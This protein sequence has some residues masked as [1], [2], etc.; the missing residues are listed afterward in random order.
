MSKF[1]RREGEASRI[2]D[3]LVSRVSGF[4]ESPAYRKL[5]DY[6]ATIP[7]VVCS[8]FA[9]Y[10]VQIHTHEMDGQSERGIRM[11]ISSAHDT[12]E[13]LAT[14]PETE[15]RNLVTDE[16]FE[17]IECRCEVLQKIKQYLMPGALALYR[18]W[19]GEEDARS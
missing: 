6:E 14:S 19:T 9:D 11:A 12:L 4:I 13:L 3:L 15:I 17:N 16:I 7:G 18:R 5:R 10:L 1:I 2:P 8:A